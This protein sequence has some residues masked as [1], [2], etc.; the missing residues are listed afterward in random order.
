MQQ[1]SCN[2]LF[3]DRYVNLLWGRMACGLLID[4]LPTVSS[5]IRQLEQYIASEEVCLH[6]FT[7]IESSPCPPGPTGAFLARSLHRDGNIS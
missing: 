7:P 1:Q 5:D 3:T 6:V 4:D 2:D